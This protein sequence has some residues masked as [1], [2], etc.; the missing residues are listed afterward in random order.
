MNYRFRQVRK[1]LGLTQAEMAEKLNKTSRMVQYYESGESN[2][3]LD[4]ILE[5]QKL[6]NISSDWLISGVGEM[7]IEKE[8]SRA[9]GMDS[10]D[11][12]IMAGLRM[13][14][15]EQKDFILKYIEE[16]RELSE[17]RKKDKIKKA[18]AG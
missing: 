14:T 7:F 1:A 13:A 2:I 5:L 15:D 16:K 4:I 18:Q 6:Y 10:R 17:L 8:K 9:K 3:E 11:A 12:L